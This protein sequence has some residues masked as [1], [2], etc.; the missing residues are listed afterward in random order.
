LGLGT[1]H[2]ISLIDEGLVEGVVG[3]FYLKVLKVVV[4]HLTS[5]T[6]YNF[7]VAI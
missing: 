3:G 4:A 2:D 1:A 5:L 7:I 6:M